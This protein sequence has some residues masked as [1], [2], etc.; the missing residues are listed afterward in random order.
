MRFRLIP[1]SRRGAYIST[2]SINVECRDIFQS[3]AI[4]SKVF[5]MKRQQQRA[6]LP[7]RS[8]ICPA[9]LTENI[10]EPQGQVFLHGQQ[11]GFMS[12]GQPLVVL[13]HVGEAGAAGIFGAQGAAH[14]SL[15]TACRRRTRHT[16]TVTQCKASMWV[17][18]GSIRHELL[19]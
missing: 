13:L 14:G 2:T 9:L 10:G 16:K 7:V 6:G 19:G 8:Q 5:W 3:Q 15:L 4:S 12:T 18:K 1:V 17:C 11:A